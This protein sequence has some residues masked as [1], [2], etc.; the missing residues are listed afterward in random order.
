MAR[1][2]HPPEVE[3]V[4]GAFAQPGPWKSER[5]ASSRNS[6]WNVAGTAC[7]HASRH[8]GRIGSRCLA[9]SLRGSSLCRAAVG[10]STKRPFQ[11]HVS[12]SREP[13]S[14]GNSETVVK[15]LPDT[16]GKSGRFARR[17]H[18]TPTVIVEIAQFRYS[19]ANCA[20]RGGACRG[21]SCQGLRCA[22]RRPGARCRC[23]RTVG[24][25]T[26]TA[27]CR[28]VAPGFD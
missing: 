10:G 25:W 15:C 9:P 27:S 12:S 24:R 7:R 2:F 16:A 21:A 8:R 3:R 20:A 4:A 17:L 28:R 23:T 22:G 1:R 19:V 18:P 11:K 5:R 26:Q 6:A 14:P 13:G